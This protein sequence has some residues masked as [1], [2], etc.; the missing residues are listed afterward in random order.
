MLYDAHHKRM[1]NE[2]EGGGPPLSIRDVARG[3]CLSRE[4]L[5]LPHVLL[6]LQQY[7]VPAQCVGLEKGERN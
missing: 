1:V 7:K 3:P 5:I 2:G 6:D 4:H